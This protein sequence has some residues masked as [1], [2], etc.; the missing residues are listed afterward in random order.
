MLSI[1]IAV[2][3]IYIS[4]RFV[5]Q[6]A[7]GLMT[8][9]VSKLSVIGGG[10]VPGA[11]STVRT[12]L[13]RSI[14]EGIAFIFFGTLYFLG[15]LGV[16]YHKMGLMMGRTATLL[17][18]FTAAVF[19]GLHLSLTVLVLVILSFLHLWVLGTWIWAAFAAM[20][21][22][23]GVVLAISASV[24]TLKEHFQ[25]EAVQAFIMWLVGLIVVSAM[26]S[27]V[28]GAFLLQIAV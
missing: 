1:S 11:I 23:I 15:I 8:A 9:V 4:R 14:M 17:H 27:V 22:S 12:I 28:V 13:G 20:L 24:R 2:L 5:S 21:G 6:E 18:S 3:D 19:M 26:F 25:L 7:V 10:V 16:A